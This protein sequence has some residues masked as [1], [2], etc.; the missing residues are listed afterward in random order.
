MASR[1]IIWSHKA[2][3]R[4]YEILKFY[5]DRN[6]NKTYSAKLYK[7]INKKVSLLK[8]QPF[9]GVRT[10]DENIR[11]LIVENYILFYEVNQEHIIIHII[12]DTRQNPDNLKIK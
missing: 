5:S 6:K 8:K 2:E 1:K 7:K 3:I 11:A 12:W 4:I 9:I 10:D